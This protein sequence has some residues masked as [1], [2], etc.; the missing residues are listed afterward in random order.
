MARKRMFDIEVVDTDFFLD[1]ST[2]ARLLYYDLGMRA[3]DD[4]FVSNPKKIMKVTN[5]SEDDFKILLAKKFIIPFENGICVI[6]HWKLNNY[7]R[8]DRYVETIYKKEKLQLEQDENGIYK[9][10]N[11]ALVYQVATSGIHSI[12]K[13]SKEE[14]SIV[15][16]SIENMSGKPDRSFKKPTVDEVKIYC[17]ER[18]NVINPQVFIDFYESKGWL[19]GKSKMKDWKAAIRTWES[20]CEKKENL[21]DWFNKDIK[22]EELD[23]KKKK[24]I[25]EMLKDYE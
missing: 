17:Q 4:G 1:M 25:E 23:P 10:N 3:D 11:D 7:L 19:V 22:S 2:G 14:Y 5:A 15:E 20:R 12:E 16:N 24:E 8:K 13:N 9:L 21:P 18:N 6:R